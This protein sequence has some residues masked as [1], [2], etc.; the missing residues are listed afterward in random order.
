M[1]KEGKFQMQRIAYLTK[2]GVIARIPRDRVVPK[3]VNFVVQ[4][5]DLFTL[6]SSVMPPLL[7]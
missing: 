1:E 4:K 3:L 6:Q 7:L 2:S 5:Y